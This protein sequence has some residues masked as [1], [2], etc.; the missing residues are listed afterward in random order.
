MA[1][2]DIVVPCYNYGRYLEACVR[3]VLD[4]SLGD[5]RILVIDDASSDDSLEVA[6]RL[7]HADERVRVMSHSR[8][9]GHIQTYNEGITWAAADYF[10]LLSADDM[11]VPGALSR[12]AAVMDAAP[13]VVLT[14]GK[15]IEWRDELPLPRV[16]GPQADTWCRQDL[17]AGS[18]VYGGNLVHTPTA[19]VRRST[20]SAI[21]GYRA[22]LPH[23]ADVE[24]WLRFAARGAVARLDAV[25]AIYRRHSDNMSNAYYHRDLGDYQ[26]RKQAFDCFF[27]ENGHRIPNAHRLRQQADQM[28]ARKVFWSGVIR[29]CRGHLEAARLL[30]RFAFD[31][32][33]ALRYRPPL[34]GAPSAF[35]DASARLFGRVRRTM[36]RRVRKSAYGR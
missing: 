17:L 35:R 28:L 7:A 15:C 11:L 13:D 22:S 26:Q 8:N 19:I 30:M 16:E 12:A 31:L 18:C 5:L 34:S 1:K 20:Q 33:P 4:Q 24:M 36:A 21:G 6:T 27:V 29:F 23:S 10:L 32:D 9:C 2:I 3:S 25:Q 14:H